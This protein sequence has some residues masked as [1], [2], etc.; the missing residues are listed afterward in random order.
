MS[1]VGSRQAS[2]LSSFLR[3]AAVDRPAQPAYIFADGAIRFDEL[4][5]QSELC[6]RGLAA[7]GIERGDRVAL[8][9]RPSQPLFVLTFGLLR[10][11]AVP[12]LIDPG[13]GRVHLARCLA[14]ASAQRLHRGLCGTRSARFAGLGERLRSHARDRR[15]AV[16]LGRR[17]LRRRD[18]GRCAGRATALSIARRKRARRHRI[19]LGEHGTTQGGGVYA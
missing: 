17:F 1:G 15:R 5:Q 6:A 2:D 9:V 10:R 13:I 3:A 7:L 14:E 18:E 8:L 16:V 12:V 19:Y 4:D 11:G